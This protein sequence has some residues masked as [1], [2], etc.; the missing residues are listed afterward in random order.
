MPTHMHEDS[1]R[2]RQAS[3]TNLGVI[4]DRKTLFVEGQRTTINLEQSF[5]DGLIDICRR[6]GRSLDGL[7]A[8]IASRRGSA[9]VTSALRMATLLYFRMT[10]D[11]TTSDRSTSLDRALARLAAGA[12]LPET[13]ERRLNA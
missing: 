2:S 6:E 8:S 3:R 12:V 5:W 4:R 11:G 7:C 1:F 13:R 10:V 9:S